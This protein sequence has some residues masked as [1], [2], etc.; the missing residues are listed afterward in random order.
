MSSNYEPWKSSEGRMILWGEVQKMPRS[1]GKQILVFF[2]KAE[3][4]LKTD[5]K[6]IKGYGMEMETKR[7]LRKAVW[8]LLAMPVKA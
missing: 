3:M 6:Q 8:N 1:W 2:L 5:R 4:N 7:G